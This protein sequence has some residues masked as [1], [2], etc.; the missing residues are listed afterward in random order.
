MIKFENVSKRYTDGTAA[1]DS[2]ELEIKQGEFFVIIGPSG[3]GKTTT[4]KMINRLIPLSDGTIYIKGKKISEYDIHELRWNI[5]YVLQQ[6]ALFPHMT[7]EENIAIVPELKQWERDRIKQRTDELL[8]MVGLDHQTYANRKPSEL[9]GGE[10][11]RVGVIRAL[12]A[13]PEILLMDE[14]FSALDPLSREKLQDDMLDLKKNLKKTTVF[15][16]HDMQE[17]L[18]LADRICIMKKGRVVQIGTPQELITNPA[19]D[20]VKNFV[21]NKHD[22]WSNDF[23]LENL[24]EPIMEEEDMQKNQVS[25]PITATMQEIVD[26]LVEYEQVI[27]ERDGTPIGL[28]NR[29]S[30][31][32]YVS[33]SLLQKGV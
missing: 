12:A 20:F 31:M 25:A 27:I 33:S 6:I 19:N 16:T 26:L 22:S 1:V 28:V 5:G 3:C 7:I 17:A 23:Q 8:E 21:G 15:V 14:P 18:K 24:L 30:I 11:Q 4:L 29:R 13:D 2:V 10:Q 32:K 9:S